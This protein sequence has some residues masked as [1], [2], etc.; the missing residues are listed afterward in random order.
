MLSNNKSICALACLGLT[1]SV[2]ALAG[3]ASADRY[4]TSGQYKQDQELA[5][6]V[7][8]TLQNAPVYKYPDAKVNVDRGRVQLSGFVGTEAQKEEAGK[9]A[10]QVPGVMQVENDLLI[11]QGAAGGA[12]TPGGSSNSTQ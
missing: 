4:R 11:K 6:K 9:I 1:L 7:H 8:D 12:T 5:E 2:L 3:C 10:S